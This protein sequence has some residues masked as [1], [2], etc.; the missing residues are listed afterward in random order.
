MNSVLRNIPIDT[1]AE[2]TANLKLLLFSLFPELFWT[3]IWFRLSFS[4]LTLGSNFSVTK[5]ERNKVWEERRIIPND[6]AASSPLHNSLTA[7]YASRSRCC[8][9]QPQKRGSSSPRPPG[10]SSEVELIDWLRYFWSF[11]C[12]TVVESLRPSLLNSGTPTQKFGIIRQDRHQARTVQ[13]V[14]RN[15]YPVPPTHPHPAPSPIIT[16]NLGFQMSGLLLLPNFLRV[17]WLP[18]PG[19]TPSWILRSKNGYLHLFSSLKES[20]LVI[21]HSVLWLIIFNKNHKYL[22]RRGQKNGIP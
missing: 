15:T 18:L 14:P 21:Q 22:F 10:S 20:T 11:G 7:V 3:M 2:W 16:L 5:K 9:L 8:L 1:W 13:I 19:K 17:H 12:I 6:L 4:F